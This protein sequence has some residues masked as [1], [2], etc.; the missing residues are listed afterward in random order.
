MSLKRNRYQSMLQTWGYAFSILVGLLYFKAD[1]YG[2][3]D[4]DLTSQT[5]DT[6]RC[7]WNRSGCLGDGLSNISGGNARKPSHDV[8]IL[9]FP[10]PRSLHREIVP[11]SQPWNNLITG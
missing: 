11:A 1:D 5:G 4:E 10:R 2:D 7:T 6:D 3:V 8:A 9:L